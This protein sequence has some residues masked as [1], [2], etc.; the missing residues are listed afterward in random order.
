[1]HT[2]KRIYFY[3][4]IFS[5]CMLM[6]CSDRTQQVQ[7][8]T[9][10][11]QSNTTTTKPPAAYNETVEIIYPS[12]VF[13]TPD[14]VQL[15]YIKAVTDSSVFESIMHDCFYQITNARRVLKQYYPRIKILEVSKARY[16]L[17]KNPR[18]DQR[19]DLNEKND[20]CG[21]FLYDGRQPARLVDMTNVDTELR[22]YFLK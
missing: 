4:S 5:A 21:L 18:G 2:V 8:N 19:I 13:Y 6:A 11:Q 16:L 20:A 15:K 3:S 9:A 12:A 17:F 14:L 7:K 10:A 1:M 22:F